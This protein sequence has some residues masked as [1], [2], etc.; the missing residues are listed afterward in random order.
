M[1]RA[2]FI[3]SIEAR[4]RES[5]AAILAQWAKPEGTQTRHFYID[6]LLPQE[7]CRAIYD[8]FLR[9]SEGFVQGQSFREKKRTSADLSSRAPILGEITYAL[10]DESIVSAIA[11]LI[12]FK[13][14]Y[15]DPQ[16]YA[17]GLS[18]M[19]KGDYLNPHID[20]SHDSKRQRYR[21][22]NALYYV[23][24]DWKLENGGNL[25]LW[26]ED[27][28]IPKPIEAKCNRLVVMET[29]KTSWHSVSKVMIES[30]RCCVSNYYFSP[31]SPDASNYFHVT[32]FTGRP[33]Q[34]VR[35]AVGI[36][37]NALRNIASK[38]LGLGRG[39]NL[40]NEKK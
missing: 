12:G 15:P 25:E 16:L 39:K 24:P 14:I 10:Q 29:N 26:N 1:K 30:P 40:M 21:R 8:A 33:D 17:G 5:E 36:V 11:S 4:L 3:E 20:N 2:A 6:A 35:R 23:A 13:N 31:E 19:F 7:C 32:S 27:C 9:D 34:P 37:D 18:M 28:T 38:T 22:L